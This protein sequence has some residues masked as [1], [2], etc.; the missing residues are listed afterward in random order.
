MNLQLIEKL[1]KEYINPTFETRNKEKAKSLYYLSF[2]GNIFLIWWSSKFLIDTLTDLNEFHYSWMPVVITILSFVF[3]IYF[4]MSKRKFLAD[5]FKE[6]YFTKFDFSANQ[7]K[8]A[9]LFCIVLVGF[10]SYMAI[11][12]AQSLSD[13]SVKDKDNIVQMVNQYADSISVTYNGKITGINQEIGILRSAISDKHNKVK[14]LEDNILA[15]NRLPNNKEAKEFIL[16]KNDIQG[17][18][19]KIN[20]LEEKINKYSAEKDTYIT[21]Y[22]TKLLDAKRDHFSKYENNVVKSLVWSIS[23]ELLV[24][25]G[26]FFYVKFNYRSLLEIDNDEHYRDLSQ[27]LL[28]L[29]VM[30]EDGKIKAHNKVI[31]ISRLPYLC[32]MMDKTLIDKTIKDKVEIF[33]HLGIIST[34]N[35]GQG[36]VAVVDYESAKQTIRTHFSF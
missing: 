26:I 32:K 14:I 33:K 5:F 20:Q 3:L 1:R 19:Q 27:S 35:K 22:N 4:E 28:I 30:Y 7:V 10:S 11:T 13:K 8:E 2:V 21:K 34:K 16:Y 15:Q 25:L 18:E 24:M 23:C 9:L 36:T 6:L 31:P 12:G 17:F 29:K